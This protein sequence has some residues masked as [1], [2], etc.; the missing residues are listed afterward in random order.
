[1]PCRWQQQSGYTCRWVHW[2]L[3][4]K[5]KKCAGEEEVFINY[6]HYE[7]VLLI[8][9]IIASGDDGSVDNSSTSFNIEGNCSKQVY[10]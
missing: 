7:L 4:H 10:S 8:I 9:I 2:T 3:C 1:M 6:Y 5:K